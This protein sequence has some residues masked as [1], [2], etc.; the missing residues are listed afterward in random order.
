MFFVEMQAELM[1]IVWSVNR[2][3]TVTSAYIDQ[4]IRGKLLEECPGQKCPAEMSVYR[5]LISS[6]NSRPRPTAIPL[7]IRPHHTSSTS[8]LMLNI[9]PSSES[10]MLSRRP[11]LMPSLQGFRGYPPR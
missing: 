3:M 6:L 8:N 5:I 2:L 7:R 4:F 1:Q 9:W 11:K 10:E